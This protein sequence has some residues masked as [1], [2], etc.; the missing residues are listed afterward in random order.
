MRPVTLGTA[1]VVIAAAGLTYAASEAAPVLLG[2]VLTLVLV[3]TGRPMIDRIER[4]F[5]E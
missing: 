5:T 4:D 1:G 2:S 3:R